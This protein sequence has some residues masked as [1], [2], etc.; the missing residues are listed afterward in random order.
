MSILLRQV[1]IAD[2]ASPFH[3]KVK[4]ILIKDQQIVSIT[5]HFEGK[6]D[7]VFEKEGTI[8]SPGWVDPF[9]HFCDPGMENRETL[10]SGA[11][12]AQKGGFTTV[13]NIPNNQPV[14][15]NKSQVTYT[16]QQSNHLPI[17]VYPIGALS[18]K[19]KER[20]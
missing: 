11:A 16:K 3:N 10:A 6:S 18:K 19:S 5:D 7:F 1:K 8:V 12:A 9:V 20:I 13:F 14:T 2:S 15:D 4:D 17:H